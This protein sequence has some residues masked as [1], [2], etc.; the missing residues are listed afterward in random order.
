MA[1]NERISHKHR[2]H[3][4]QQFLIL[5]KRTRM[6]RSTNLEKIIEFTA[7]NSPYR[8]LKNITIHAKQILKIHSGTIITFAQNTG[9]IAHGK[10]II[11][12]TSFHKIYPFHLLSFFLKS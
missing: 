8:I 10:I 12:S 9:I 4:N 11:I 6:K 3:H 5:E 2:K 7:E 1:I